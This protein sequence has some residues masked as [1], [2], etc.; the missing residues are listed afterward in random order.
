L[1][2]RKRPGGYQEE[3]KGELRRV[4]GAGDGKRKIVG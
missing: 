1:R 2:K 4:K 3:R